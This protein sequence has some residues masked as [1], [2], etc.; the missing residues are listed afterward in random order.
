M[1]QS[2]KHI[3]IFIFWLTFMMVPLSGQA[4]D[5]GTHL[6][7]NGFLSQGYIDSH[8]NNFLGDTLDGSFQ[9]NEFGLTFNSELTENLRIGLQLLSRDLGE[10]GNNKIIIDWG[11][12]D[13]RWR[14]W[15]GVRVGKVKLPIG[16]Y[17]Q[18]RDSDFLRP[19]VFLPQSIYDENKR[20]LYVAAT[21][22]SLYGN[23]T[24]GQ[25][26]DLAYQAYYGQV[27]FHN[28][29]GQARGMRSLVTSIAT[30]KNLGTASSFDAKNR[31]VYGGSLVYTPPL[32][33]IRFGV[34]YFTGKSE[35][36]FDL[37]SLDTS[38]S[39]SQWI[40]RSGK[41]TGHNK[42][43]VVFSFEYAGDNFLFSTEY[44]EFTGDRAVLDID[45]PDGRSQG[46]YVQ[47]CYY[48]LEPVG[49][50]VLYDVF[51]ADKHDHD[52]SNLVAQGQ[53]DFWGWRKDLGFGVHWDVNE[54]WRL[55]AEWH[56]VN[57]AALQLPLYNPDGAKEDWNY[58]V[59]KASY[60]F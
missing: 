6:S 37:L 2:Q 15:L 20:N 3:G 19:M 26:G 25:G 38:G 24:L 17:N 43:F 58:V 55:K 11:M 27:T 9:F 59:F 57:G 12:I 28:D 53:P 14:D 32:E 16:L 56:Q 4:F 49:L 60:N 10:E 22:G 23:L 30:K 52:G 47:L 5:L 51:Y 54:N 31:Y 46:G 41:A 42:D 21:G 8:T 29:S 35:F 44:M 36:E 1:P 45:I 7:V 39:E 40:S 48:P 34:S 33:R 18:G 13:Y 50:S